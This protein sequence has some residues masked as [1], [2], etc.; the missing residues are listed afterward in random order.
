M[1]DGEEGGD[2]KKTRK[3]KCYKRQRKQRLYCFHL[4]F[5][6]YCSQNRQFPKN[7]F[8][9]DDFDLKRINK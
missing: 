9:L 2:G 1:E 7:R 6:P 8:L 5:I 3:K 4:I